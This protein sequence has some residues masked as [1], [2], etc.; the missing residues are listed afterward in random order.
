MFNQRKPFQKKPFQKGVSDRKFD[1]KSD[2][3]FD[4]KPRSS[5]TRV[6]AI[7]YKLAADAKIDYKDFNLLQKY[8]TERGKILSRRITGLSAKQQR[9]LT[10]AIKKARFLS[11]FNPAVLSKRS[12]P[13]EFIP[14]DGAF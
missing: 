5:R 3:K 13:R 11:L 12:S 6:P 1:K 7:K 10:R 14:R 9:E 2:R 8:I 4:R